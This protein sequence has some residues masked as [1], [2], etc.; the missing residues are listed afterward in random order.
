MA[1]EVETDL[2]FGDGG[3]IILSSFSLSNF[4]NL[5]DKVHA[6]VSCYPNKHNPT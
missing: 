2:L 1:T 4:S 5:I 6:T 3:S